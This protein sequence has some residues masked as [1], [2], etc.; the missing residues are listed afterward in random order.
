LGL[1]EPLNQSLATLTLR[2][3]PMMRPAVSDSR[4]PES[5]RPY[6]EEYKPLFSDRKPGV[7]GY[8]PD[9]AYDSFFIAPDEQFPELRNYIESLLDL[10]RADGKVP[11]L[12]FCRSLG[13][14]E[15]FRRNF[16]DA[17]HIFVMRD[18]RSQWMSAWRLSREDDN[19]H[20]LLAPIRILALHH[21]HPLVALVLEALRI[22]A[23]DFV[24]PDKHAAICKAV[25][26]TPAQLLYR[27]FLAFWVL[28]SFLALPECD[29]TIE[30]ERLSAGDFRATT[31]E[32]IDSLTGISID[33][34]DAYSIGNTAGFNDFFGAHQAR[35]DALQALARLEELK[36]NR[37]NAGRIL[38]DKLTEQIRIAS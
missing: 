35:V 12:K 22:R 29:M 2:T 31:Q 38:G 23:E 24:L 10:A 13:R 20:H 1:Y 25:H 36:P 5:Q 32:V 3:L 28:S 34:G 18:P 27:G 6:F 33:L 21:E 30:T 17:A 26:R 8:R 37:G 9:F 7:R 4:H 16:P 11:V 15:W 14:V 19:P